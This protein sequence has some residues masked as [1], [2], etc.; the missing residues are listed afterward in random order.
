MPSPSEVLPTTY[1]EW[2]KELE[3]PAPEVDRGVPIAFMVAWGA[4]ST[5]ALGSGALIGYRSFDG[6]VAYEALDHKLERPTPAAE[7]QATR[8]A[9][10]ALGLGTVAAFGTAGIA[11]AAAYALGLRSAADVTST[12]K[13]TLGPL[14]SWLRGRGNWLQS[15]ADGSRALLDGFC[16]GVADRWQAS[17]AGGFARRRIGGGAAADGERSDDGTE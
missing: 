16:D 15:M 9:V 8:L 5:M 12:A 1:A 7:A 13:T 17:W 10:R 3:K 4:I 14:D 6:S 2:L 11:V